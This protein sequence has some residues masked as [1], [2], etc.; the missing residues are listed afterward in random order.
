VDPQESKAGQSGSSVTRLVLSCAI[1]AA[2]IVPAALLIAW[3]I[4]GRQ[5]SEE[6]LSNAALAGGVCFVAGGL[7]LLAVFLGNRWQAGVQGVLVG[8]LFRMGLPLAAIVILP[9]LGGPFA[10]PGA[11]T[12]ILGVYLVALVVETLL[13]LR[14]VPPAQLPSTASRK[15]Q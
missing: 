15:A 10:A 5:F 4:G 3:L 7:A 13:S 12:T 6:V 8:M 11:A 1:L 9:K 2:A 14:M